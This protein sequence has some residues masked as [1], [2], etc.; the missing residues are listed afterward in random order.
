MGGPAKTRSWR[1]PGTGAPLLY[2][3]PVRSGC[4]V[5]VIAL[6]GA[7][8]SL[9]CRAAL[10]TA[11]VRAVAASC[12]EQTLAIDWHKCNDAAELHQLELQAVASVHVDALRAMDWFGCITAARG[13]LSWWC[14]ASMTFP[15]ITGCV[16]VWGSVNRPAY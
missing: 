3:W 11:W 16:A 2:R 8:G 7:V 15:A 1:L 5:Q 9:R 14:H 13:A 10:V 4:I 6:H 12:Q